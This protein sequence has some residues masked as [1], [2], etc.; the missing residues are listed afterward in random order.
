MNNKGD[1]TTY[2]NT[3]TDAIESYDSNTYTLINTYKPY[4]CN[5]YLWYGIFGNAYFIDIKCS[6]QNFYKNIS[7][8]SIIFTK[9]LLEN[10]MQLKI[11]DV[12]LSEGYLGVMIRDAIMYIKPSFNMQTLYMKLNDIKDSE[13]F[14]VEENKVPI[15][16]YELV[17]SNPDGIHAESMVLINGKSDFNGYDIVINVSG[18]I[19]TWVFKNM[20]PLEEKAWINSNGEL[21]SRDSRTYHIGM[22]NETWY[23][24]V[25]NVLYLLDS[26]IDFSII[27]ESYIKNFYV[28]KV[29][30]PY[31]MKGIELPFQYWEDGEL[32][33][34][35]I[36]Y[37]ITDGLIE[38]VY[39]EDEYVV[40]EMKPIDFSVEFQIFH[41]NKSYMVS[42]Y[43]LS[44][45]R[46]GETFKNI[47]YG[48]DLNLRIIFSKICIHGTT[49]NELKFNMF[50][51]DVI[52]FN[53]YDYV[54]EPDWIGV[55]YL[56]NLEM[57]RLKSDTIIIKELYFWKEGVTPIGDRQ[58][59][60]EKFD[61]NTT[62][63]IIEFLQ[64]TNVINNT[65]IK[66]G[67][68]PELNI[69]LS[70]ALPRW[71]YNEFLPLETNGFINEEGNMVS[72]TSD[73]TKYHITYI[74]KM[75]FE[76]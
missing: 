46:F 52:R 55:Q 35:E 12:N 28:K 5:K 34:S 66:G 47:V 61:F 30:V 17:F 71:I 56:N 53:G 38:R 44:V 10:G 22:I 37:I 6:I 75:P 63:C 43:L 65:K 23:Q 31:A 1:S 19:P 14:F 58:F 57:F 70:G 42:A 36:K 32:K 29:G 20:L 33:P 69:I 48:K 24:N 11:L 59:E 39:E 9:A 67:M 76:K 16:Q 27:T 64:L 73:D 40:I 18:I 68:N 51:S 26:D 25:E 41:E 3:E 8:V 4:I 62:N 74:N 72:S 45:G 50:P 2:F 7:Y 54:I 13:E 49:V 21:V 60:I 15:Q